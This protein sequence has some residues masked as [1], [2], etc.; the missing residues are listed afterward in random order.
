MEGIWARPWETLA[1]GSNILIV[2][3]IHNTRE[4]IPGGEREGIPLRIL[5][6]W[7]IDTQHHQ[8]EGVEVLLLY[9]RA[10]PLCYLT[11]P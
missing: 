1:R 9:L 11:G 2:P 10:R 7:L 8:R 5:H 3:I 4:V 6:L